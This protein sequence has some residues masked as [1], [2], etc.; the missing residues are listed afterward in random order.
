MLKKLL[1]LLKSHILAAFIPWIFFGV[2]YG[3]S[4]QLLVLS[5]SGALGLTLLC[6]FKELK[7]GFVLPWGSA[8][9]F[10]FLVVNGRFMLVDITPTGTLRLIHS[11]LAV[12]VCFSMIIGK[13]FTL[14]YAKEEVDPKYWQ[15][16]DFLKINWILA[17][18]WSILLIIMALPSYF[19]RYDQVHNSWFWSYG[20]MVLCIAIGL[21]CNKHLPPLLRK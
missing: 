11:A 18:I 10:T 9:L 17:G 19:L 7:K 4:T 20:L 5:S 13:P 3:N 16:T 8:A 14:Q 6:N 21:Q 12:I 1:F 2:F 15:S